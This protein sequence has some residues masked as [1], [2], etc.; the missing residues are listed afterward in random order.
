MPEGAC[1]EF[2]RPRKLSGDGSRKNMKRNIL[3]FSAEPGGAETLTPVIRLLSRQNHYAIV[4]L[5]Y[6]HGLKRFQQKGVSCI[7][8]ERI[9]MHD[10]ALI[11][12]YAPDFIITSATSL[13]KFD[14]SEKYLWRSANKVGIRTLAFLDQWQ[15]YSQRFSGPSDNEMLAYLPDFINCIDQTGRVEMLEEGFDGTRLISLGHP[16]LSSIREAYLT[17]TP[18]ELKFKIKVFAGRCTP[19]N[20]LL[21]VSEPLREHFG[22]SRGYDQYQTLEYFLENVLRSAPN[23]TVLIKLH[24][25]DLLEYFQEIALRYKALDLHFIRNELSSLECLRAAETVFGMTSIMLIEAFI[26]G[27][28]VV[29]LQPGLKIA[30]PLVL[31]RHGYIPLLTDRSNFNILGFNRGSAENIAVSFNENAFLKLIDEHMPEESAHSSLVDIDLLVREG[32]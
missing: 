30:D 32:K 19:Q 22:S 31:T 23:L 3:V 10:L 18:E 26:L 9:A 8:V 6:G 17:D 25:K 14:M 27:K 4:V 11:K 15:N 7:E 1:P 21:F 16:Y 28:I 24:P 2:G 13:A 20:T 5:G 29:S 12:K